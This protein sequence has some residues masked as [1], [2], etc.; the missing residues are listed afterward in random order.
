MTPPEAYKQLLPLSFLILILGLSFILIKWPRGRSHTFSQH[1][2]ASKVA[3]AFYIGLFL[4]SL[5]PL[6][7]FITRWFVPTYHLSIWFLVFTWVAVIAQLLCTFIPE[8]GGRMTNWH[9]SLAFLSADMLLPLV[10]LVA[11]HPHI[12]GLIIMVYFVVVLLPTKGYHR[13]VLIIQSSYFAC[14]FVTLLA[15]TYITG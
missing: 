1:I 6:M 8:V 3:I 4:V 14:F 12:S 15:A 7:L 11:I 9:R 10:L 13:N 5:T 2:A